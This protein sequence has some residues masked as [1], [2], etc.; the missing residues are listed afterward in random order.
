MRYFMIVA[1]CVAGLTGCGGDSG[2]AHY[3]VSGTI[4]INGEPAD[5]LQVTFAPIGDVG[6]EAAGNVSNGT[7]TMFSGVKGTPGVQAGKYK[8]LLQEVGDTSYMEDPNENKNVDPTQSKS[9]GG[10]IPVEYADA[11]KE[12]EVTEGDNKIDIEI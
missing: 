11:P 6:A 8:V 5:G 9:T 2:P 10:K 7:Y 12:V 3:P 1:L 4:T